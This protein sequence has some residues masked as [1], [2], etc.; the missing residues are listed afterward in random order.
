MYKYFRTLLITATLFIL[1]SNS[2]LAQIGGRQ[3]YEF[4]NLVSSARIAG[5]GG[6]F[7]A[8]KDHDISLTLTN[9]SLITPEMHNNISMNFVN[10]FT[11]LNYGSIM[12]SM[13]FNKIGSFVGTFQFVDYGRFTRA[14]ETG[15][16][17]GEFSASEYA[18]NIGWGRQ[19]TPLFSIGANGKLIY[20]HLDTY[21]SFG[22]A[23]DIAGSYISKNQ[24]FTASLLAR[25]IG[26]QIVGYRAG[27]REPL[28]FELQ[29]GISQKLKHIPLRFSLLYNHIEKWDLRYDDPN[30]PSN[31]K[32]PLTGETKTESD[33][34]KFAD[35]FMRHI[36]I[37]G[38]FIIAKTFSIRLGYNYQRR[39]ELK[40]YG[41]S[42]M[43]GFT[44][45]FGLHIKMFDFSYTRATYMAGAINP[46]YITLAANLGAFTKKK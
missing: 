7:L 29:A 40:I 36:V 21:N 43:S 19:L 20:S 26:I 11:G 34:S 37:G 2:I 3:T 16:T 39:Q 9:P 41:K 27:H 45:G 13:T 23:V 35:N 8:V 28:P 14:D 25:N 22:I 1:V 18:L 44:Y 46:N 5:L 42:G 4:L 15:V 17:Y 38:E 32:D 30:D 24:L 12:Y 31:Q 6:N 10:Y 33:L